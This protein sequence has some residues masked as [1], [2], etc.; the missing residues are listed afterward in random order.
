MQARGHDPQD[1]SSQSRRPGRPHERPGRTS[2]RSRGTQWRRT[3]VAAT[4]VAVLTLAATPRAVRACGG[5]FCNRPPVNS[6]PLIAQAAENVVFVLDRDQTTGAGIVEAHVQIVYSGDVDKFSWIVPV[7]SLP[8]LGVGNDLL[9]QILEPRTRPTFNLSWTQ[10]GNC[11]GGGGGFACG[12]AS[13]SA[14]ANPGGGPQDAGKGP[15]AV[16]VAF[17]GNVG[18]Y[19][20]AIVRSDDPQALETWLV[21]NQ[22]YVSPEASQIIT[23]YVNTGSY[24]VALRLQQGRDVTEIQPIVLK[25]AA[26]EGCLPLKLTAIASTQDL[27]I[28]IWVLGAGRAVPLNYTEISLNLLKLD[29]FSQG[30][31][32]DKLLGEAANEAGGNAFA[33]EYAQPASLSQSWFAVPSTA[34]SSLMGATTPPAFWNVLQQLGLPLSGRVLQVLR[35]YIPEPAAFVAQGITEAQFYSSLPNFFLQNPSAFGPFNAAAAATAIDTQVLRP[36]AGLRSLFETHQTLTRVATFIS[37]D[38]M[39]KDP[40]FVT[41]PTLPGLSNVHSAVAHLLCGD[42]DYS[43]CDAPVRVD[44]EGQPPG[45]RFRPPKGS[46]NSQFAPAVY[47]R[48]DVDA[49]MPAA[50]RGWRRDPT[51]DGDVILDNSS[52]IATTLLLHNAAVGGGGGGSGC[53]CATTAKR[54]RRGLPGAALF[55]AGA[56]AIAWRRGR[57]GPRE[58]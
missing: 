37:P 23:G 3:A 2:R 29:W 42:E 56:L 27:R 35:E 18:P 19:E 4:A 30:G 54:A 1:P 55:L 43:F 17:R 40:L 13:S 39:I 24:F 33:I 58:K 8:T 38:E 12:G 45:I 34:L 28:N 49:K 47:D 32:Y 48:T 21:D 41:N 36:M 31:N 20:T 46:C 15:H 44:V 6:P 52:A 57:R 11:Q 22:Y 10:D 9:F 7:T 50:D 26:E 16:D 53:A 14:T 51:G 5:F 25:L